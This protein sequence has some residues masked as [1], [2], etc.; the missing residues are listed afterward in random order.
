VTT[1]DTVPR[2]RGR[3]RASSAGGDSDPREG[4]VAAAGALFGAHGVEAVTMSQIADRAGLKQSSIYYWFGSKAE[5]LASILERVNRD[6]LAI[7][8]RA[9]SAPGPVPA[10]LHRLVHD[11]VVALCDLPFDINEVHRLALR[12]PDELTSYWEE[13]ERLRS[14][15]ERLLAEGV[16]NGELRS[17]DVGLA[18]RTVLAND[19]GSQDW[20]RSPERGGYDAEA[21]AD[22]LAESTVRSLLADP[23]AYERLVD[24][25]G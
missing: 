19:E 6:P 1:D 16:A 9:L 13:R 11:D 2:R 3:P 4:I 20:I 8:E 7:V 18:A 24:A 5:I 21:V 23:S 25:A 22:H 12:A 15:V 14:G 17:V 10:R